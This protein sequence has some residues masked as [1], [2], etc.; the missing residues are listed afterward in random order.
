MGTPMKAMVYR[1][2]GSPDVLELQD[3]DKPAVKDGDVLVRVYAAAGQSLRLAPAA[4]P[5]LHRST[6]LRAGERRS[7]ISPAPTSRASS[8]RSGV[9]VT[10][11]K[12]GDEV[13]GEKSRACAEYVSGPET[14][15]VHRPTNLTLEQAATIPVAAITALQALRDKGGIQAGQSVLIDGASGGVGT[16]A[17]QLAKAFGGVVT[18]VC[19]TRN[20]ELVRSLGADHVIDYT[21]EDFTRGTKRYDL[22]IDN[23]GNHRCWRSGACSPRAGR[24]IL[25]AATRARQLDRP[26]SAASS[27]RPRCRG[28]GARSSA[29][30]LA[31]MQPG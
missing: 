10:L 28:S 15:F 6:D 30:S 2:Y 23:A 1:R 12:P 31:D 29:R 20:V 13:F 21:R 25:S 14:L 18:G 9:N 26:R 22:I 24:L 5:A 3:V 8:R 4:R 17:V 7:A 19:S 16:F 11:L 27:R